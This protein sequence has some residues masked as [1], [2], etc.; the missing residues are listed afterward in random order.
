MAD[1]PWSRLGEWFTSHSTKGKGSGLHTRV[2]F[3][4]LSEN[5]LVEILRDRHWATVYCQPQS[6]LC[7]RVES[8]GSVQVDVS[9]CPPV[10]RGGRC[11]C[12]CAC[13]CVRERE[14]AIKLDGRLLH[15]A[16]CGSGS[17]AGNPDYRCNE[18]VRQPQCT[19]VSSST[20]AL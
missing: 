4:S 14:R 7:T 10:G 1:R 8:A 17:S 2:H 6:W 13:V 18:M 9:A 3:G 19:V 16:E 20:C 11:V 5:L 15:C 12:V